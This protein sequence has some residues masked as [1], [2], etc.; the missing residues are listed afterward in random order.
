MAKRFSGCF[1]TT[2]SR[3]NPSPFSPTRFR[4][5]NGPLRSVWEITAAETGHV[6]AVRI[7]FDPTR[8]RYD[9]LLEVFWRQIDPTDEGGRFV[10]RGTSHFAAVFVRDASERETAESSMR[11]LMDSGRF[12]NPIVTPIREASVFYAAEDYHQN[13]Y[14]KSKLKC[15]YYRFRSGR[16]AFIDKAWGKERNY[17]PES[18]ESSVSYKQF[19]KLFERFVWLLH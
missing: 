8:I 17:Q 6:E 12:E 2:P 11:R 9:D 7:T 18:I 13:D 10:D 5:R 14:Q 4:A 3:S 16:P 1:F 19:A 15:K